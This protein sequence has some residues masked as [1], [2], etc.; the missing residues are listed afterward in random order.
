[1]VAAVIEQFSENPATS[2]SYSK[3]INERHFQ[4][5]KGLLEAS[6]NR[7]ERV[8]GL[9]QCIAARDYIPPTIVT[10]VGPDERLMQEEIFGP[11]LPVLSVRDYR[12]AIAFI[13]KR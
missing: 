6:P 1:M 13:N 8:G 11:I 2:D 5:L 4:R 10:G 3:V 12:E 7:V 9:D